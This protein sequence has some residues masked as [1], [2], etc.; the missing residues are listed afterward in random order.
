MSNH[1]VVRNIFWSRQIYQVNSVFG[2][3]STRS[4][5]WCK[6]QVNPRQWGEDIIDLRD[7]QVFS[8][9][10]VQGAGEHGSPTTKYYWLE[11]PG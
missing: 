4:I 8:V 10:F 3:I 7:F 6:F 1:E 2:R 9:E 5:D 11:H